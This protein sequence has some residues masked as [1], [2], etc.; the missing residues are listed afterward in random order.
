L[1]TPE[2]KWRGTISKGKQAKRE[3]NYP[4]GSQKAGHPKWRKAP[5]GQNPHVQQ[6]SPQTSGT[7]KSKPEP[8]KGT[9]EKKFPKNPKE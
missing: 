1:K 3:T 2:R 4:P 5:T 6:K 8:K 9:G 7:Q